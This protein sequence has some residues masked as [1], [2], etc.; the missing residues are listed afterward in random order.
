MKASVERLAPGVVAAGG[1]ADVLDEHA[2]VALKKGGAL[3][4]I[5]IVR[6]ACAP[7]RSVFLGL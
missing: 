7:S 5:Y 2:G 1:D 4:R 6:R 3:L